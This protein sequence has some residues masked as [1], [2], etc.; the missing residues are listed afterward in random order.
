MDPITCK[1]QFIS[2]SM[3]PH[4]TLVSALFDPKAAFILHCYVAIQ[5]IDDVKNSI[6]TQC[7]SELIGGISQKILYFATAKPIASLPRSYTVK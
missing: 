3:F 7:S 5:A 1:L 4:L 6:T 2:N